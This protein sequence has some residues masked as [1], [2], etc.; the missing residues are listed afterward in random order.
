VRNKIP[1]GRMFGIP[2]GLDY[3]WFLV[4][5]LFTWMLAVGYFPLKYSDWPPYLYWVT[6]AATTIML[7]VSVLLHEF[8]HS[9]MAR[10]YRLKVRSITLFI[11][12]G[13]SEITTEPPN[14]KVEFWVAL[15]GPLVSFALA[16]LFFV[17]EPLAAG[18]EP[19]LAVFQYLALINFVLAVFNLVPGFPLDG[20]RVFRALVWARTKDFRR[21]T[22]TAGNAGRFFGYFFIMIGVWFLLLGDLFDGLWIAFIGWFLESAAVGQIQQQR[23][24]TLLSGHRVSEAMSRHYAAIDAAT[25]LE[26][27]VHTHILGGGQ[28]ALIVERGGQI[29]GLLTLDRIKHVPRE[30]W[31][32]TAAAE[33][34]I[35]LDDL[36]TTRPDAELWSA[37]QEMDRDGVN[38]LPV[39][40]D[41]RLVGLLSRDDVINYLRTL[42]E[43]TPLRP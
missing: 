24:Q 42:T 41:G 20:G 43:L 23:I 17:L 37:L 22:A 12:G 11:F 2:V 13:V 18:K 7:F 15:A 35:P 27:V 33:A 4:F 9:L 14:A 40:E 29:V 36:R 19:V 28:R 39:L 16:G 1:L 10:H 34:M 30:A 26:E 21:A 3:S 6:G 38:Q 31:P 25:P 32:E 8:G 5:I